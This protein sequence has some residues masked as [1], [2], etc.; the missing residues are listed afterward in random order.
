MKRRRLLRDTAIALLLLV[1]F[2]YVLYPQIVMLSGS[3]RVGGRFSFDRYAVLFD[4]RNSANVEAVSNSLILSTLSVVFSAIIGGLFAFTFTQIRFPLGKI[5]SRLAVLPI[6]LPP[7]V[8]VIAFLF[9][10][11]ESGFLP[12]IL[13]KVLMLRNVPFYLNGFNAVVAVHVYSFYVYFYLF[14]STSLRQLDGSLIEAASSLGSSSWNTFRRVILPELRP[15]IIGASLL[16]FMTSMASFSAPLIFGGEHRFLTTQIY[17]TKLNGEMDAAAA[18]SM[19]LTLVSVGFFLVLTFSW[20]AVEGARRTKGA[21][22]PAEIR[23]SPLTRRVLIGLI[24]FLLLLEVLPILTLIV[25][26]FVKEGSWTWQMFPSSYTTEN[27]AKLF[28]DPRVFEPIRNSVV[29]AGLAVLAGLIVGVIASFVLVK[30]GLKKGRIALDLLLSLSYAIPGT[31]IAIGLI[32]TFNSP[33][34]W[35]GLRFWLERSGSSPSHI[36]S[37]ATLSLSNRHRR[38]SNIWMIR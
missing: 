30:G 32:Y 27:Y 15:A 19:L 35:A 7:L 5:S 20:K 10:F 29:M 3:L 34:L 17:S 24:G 33:I 22:R 37:G 13:Q 1:V 12:R 11:G 38:R 8:G 26:S 4:L 21:V 16:T 28:L 2:G 14:I 36:S 9:V 31:V 25:I 6:A 18:Q 23:I